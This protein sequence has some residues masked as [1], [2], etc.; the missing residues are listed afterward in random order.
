MPEEGAPILM[1]V[2]KYYEL[3]EREDVIVELHWGRLV[4]L[5]RPKP[6]MIKLRHRIAELLEA[7]CG[8]DW[9]VFHELPFRAVP[10]YDLRGVN[11]GVIAK[12]RWDAVGE[13]DLFGSPEIVIEILSPSSSDE[14]IA[15]RAALFLATGT[16]QFCLIDRLS[17]TVSMT[18]TG[19]KTIVYSPGGEVPYPLLGTSLKVAEI[20]AE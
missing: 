12:R 17:R 9:L 5:P 4:E 18:A 13:S 11:I 10:Q 7:R 2:E 6:W 1:T 8:P 15:E 16:M 3:P 19:E 14:E 20:W